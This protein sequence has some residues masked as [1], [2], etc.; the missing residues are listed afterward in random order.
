M[1]G[2]IN[3][4]DRQHKAFALRR[5]FNLSSY[6][7]QPISR[8]SRAR[9]C[10]LSLTATAR[11]NHHPLSRI[12]LLYKSLLTTCI[13][14]L[15]IDETEEKISLKTFQNKHPTRKYAY[16]TSAQF[17]ETSLRYRKSSTFKTFPSSC[18]NGFL[19]KHNGI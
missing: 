6:C 14:W 11:D 1:C 19:A 4:T 5:P 13:A 10:Y 15:S 7:Q 2:F 17:A 12:A 3:F 18:T 9:P 8:F 16:S